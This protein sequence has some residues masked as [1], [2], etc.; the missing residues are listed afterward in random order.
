MICKKNPYSPSVVLLCKMIVYPKRQSKLR[1]DQSLQ[2]RHWAGILKQTLPS[3]IL[4]L[5]SSEIVLLGVAESL[6]SPCCELSQA[7]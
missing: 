2:S 4:K 7:V 1:I 6:L 3:E 5:D